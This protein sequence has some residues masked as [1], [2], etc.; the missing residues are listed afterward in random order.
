M[1]RARPARGYANEC[2]R[3]YSH[4]VMREWPLVGRTQTLR[5]LRESLTSGDNGIVIAGAIGVGKSRLAAEGLN[6]AERAGMAT[7]RVSATKASSC[8][9]L[10][11][12]APLLPALHHAEVG[13]V[14]DR[15]DLLR[16]C[17]TA[18]VERA[19]DRRLVLH[20]DDAHLLD[21]MSAT[22]VHQLADSHEA[23]LLATIRSCEPAPDPVVA[24]WKDGL[25]ERMEL[26]GL[27]EE[28][29]G[30]ALSWALGGPVDDAAVAD[31][32]DR[33]K[34]NMLFL[35]E[36]VT[37]AID[38]GV[39]SDDGGVWRL[40]GDLHPTDR[41][42]ELV[43]AR[44]SGLAPDERA[45]MEAVSFGEPLGPAEL[46]ALGDLSVAE[47]LERRGL[48][49]STVDGRRLLVSLAHPLYGE[50]LRSR[51]PA[52]RARSIARSL[53]EAVEATGAR[54]KEDALRVATWRLA[55]GGAQPDLMLHAATSA[56]WRYD[57]DLAER[58]AKAAVDAG[59]G[60]DAEMLLAQLAGLQGRSAEA[61]S[62]LAR[63]SGEAEDDRQRG[64]ITLSRLDN[65][66][67]YAGTIEEG[68]KIAEEAVNALDG[69]PMADEI[70]ARQAAL[71][72]AQDGPKAAAGVAEPLLKR[73]HGRALVWACM[74]GAYSLARV[75]RIAEALDA[76]ERGLRA[77]L[78]LNQPMDWYPWMHRFYE[79]EALAHAGHFGEAEDMANQQ[80]GEAL[81]QR[82]VEAQGIFAWQ[83]S[84]SVTDRGH[85]DDAVRNAQVA[86]AIYRQLDRPQFVYFCLIYLSLCHAIGRRYDEASQALA[87]LDGLG[88]RTNH[89][90]GIDLLLA[91]AWTDVAGGNL[92]HASIGFKDA[93]RRGEK[94]GDLVGAAA[95]LH[96]LARIGH[97][98]EAISSLEELSAEIEG[99]LA[100]ART[101]HVQA[102]VAGRPDNL[103]AVCDRFES[104]GADLLAAEAAADAAVA[105][106]K[107]GEGRQAAAAE[108]RAAWLASRCKGANTPALQVAETRA[109]LTSAEWEA[110][111]LAAVG[112]SNKHIAEEL[113]V[114]VRTVENRL[115]HVYGKL[116]VSGRSQLAEALETIQGPHD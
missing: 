55:S 36:L 32:A 14:D 19:G 35:R 5:Y 63:L 103:A 58:L 4:A 84:K 82:S 18:L 115:Q 96:S 99:E 49:H 79:C 33:S 48:L 46:D 75:G 70:V 106:R 83:M 116:G 41:V 112:H 2:D 88:L 13:V 110:A 17:E 12:F 9:P 21:D 52:L 24:L 104:M 87:A 114:S 71:L 54:R 31:L 43:E 97:A 34:G 20:V 77:Q 42:V 89:F 76:T 28:A 66:V 11:A 68:I 93:A 53:A 90:M 91:R 85:V 60:F 107:H 51:V 7:A 47:R 27:N 10:G 44:L 111:Q 3:G 73:A 25:A 6:L 26:D 108:R 109:R 67:I 64:L 15:A 101:A 61:A 22:L 8:I 29:V 39:L 57:F 37:G 50:V 105:W 62:E 94:I 56:R 98:K 74:P 113:F 38:E 65:R 1:T 102:L 100:P 23:L 40:V 59:A 30:E 69:T 92:R 81:E 80:Y 72:L 78:E 86:I 16:R 45:L 95:A